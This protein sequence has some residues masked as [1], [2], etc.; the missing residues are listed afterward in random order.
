MTEALNIQCFHLR[1]RTLYFVI[2][3]L[4]A[5]E[6]A[7]NMSQR[8]CITPVHSSTVTAALRNTARSTPHQ[9]H[10]T[11]SKSSHSAPDPG[12]ENQG[13]L[14]KASS[15]HLDLRSKFKITTPA[16]VTS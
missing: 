10:S 1:L 2:H 16:T 8:L 11:A 4:L 12:P 7:G 15:E 6:S 9:T 14:K 13:Y 3:A 5:S